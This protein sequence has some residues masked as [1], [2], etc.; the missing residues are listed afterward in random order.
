MS[1]RI[2]S[3]REKFLYWKKAFESKKL[4]ISLKKTKMMVSGSKELPRSKIDRCAK[5][6]NRVMANSVLYTKCGKWVYGKYENM[7]KV[8]ST[9]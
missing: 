3:L 4:K 7:K 8:H 1:K 6:G 5:C 9:S 2:E